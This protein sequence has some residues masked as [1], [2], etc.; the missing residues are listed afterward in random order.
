VSE[1][2]N[3]LTDSE[4]MR[5][6]AGHDHAAFDELWRRYDKKV[7]NYFRSRLKDRHLA[8][9]CC[10][11]LFTEVWENAHRHAGG[12]VWSFIRAIATNIYRNEVKK[13]TKLKEVPLATLSTAEQ[14]GYEVPELVDRSFEASIWAG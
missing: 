10:Q 9:D 14:E 4:L 1:D 2:D 6:V 13:S 11:Q 8:N 3:T 7:R 12:N 5:R